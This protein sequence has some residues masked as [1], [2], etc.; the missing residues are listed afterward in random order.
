MKLLQSGSTVSFCC[1]TLVC[2]EPSRPTMDN[3]MNNNKN[4][5]NSL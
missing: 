3:D 1:L 4:P 5:I 2:M